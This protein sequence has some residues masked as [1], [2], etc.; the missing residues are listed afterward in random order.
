[1][2]T[3]DM[4]GKEY[5]ILV[6]SDGF[7]VNKAEIEALDRVGLLPS[8]HVTRTR[9]DDDEDMTLLPDGSYRVC[10]RKDAKMTFLTPDDVANFDKLFSITVDEDN[11]II[12]LGYE[13]TSTHFKFKQY[14][15]ELIAAYNDVFNY[16]LKIGEYCETWC[17]TYPGGASHQVYWDEIDEDTYDAHLGMFYHFAFPTTDFGNEIFRKYRDEKDQKL[18]DQYLESCMNE[19]VED[20]RI[21]MDEKG[22]SESDANYLIHSGDFARVGPGKYVPESEFDLYPKYQ[23]PMVSDIG[24]PNVSRAIL[25]RALLRKKRH[26]IDV[27]DEVIDYLAYDIWDQCKD[28]YGAPED[29]QQI[30]AEEE[31]TCQEYIDG[32]ELF[33]DDEF[34]KE[35]RDYYQVDEHYIGPSIPN[36]EGPNCRLPDE[37]II[38]DQFDDDIPF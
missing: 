11:S 30:I 29:H 26:I 31:M 23:Y 15:D 27:P 13:F 8:F 6:A 34:T 19:E 7:V 28:C 37:P 12:Y 21:L 9:W 1:M 25:M 36:E 22:M 10:N 24:S 4:E 18:M 33:R 2:I 20:L 17:L 35:H 5:L 38:P 32:E 3:F 16:K 14:M